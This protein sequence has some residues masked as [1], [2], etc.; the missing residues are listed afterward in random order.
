MELFLFKIIFYLI[1]RIGNK[2]L[3]YVFTALMHNR[4]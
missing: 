4:E 2:N 1:E 3:Q